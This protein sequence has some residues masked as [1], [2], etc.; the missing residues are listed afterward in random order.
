MAWVQSGASPSRASRLHGSRWRQGQ[1]AF[2]DAFRR[3][4]GRFRRWSG[5]LARLSTSPVDKLVEKRTGIAGKGRSAC[6]GSPLHKKQADL[7]N[8]LNKMF[9]VLSTGNMTV[10]ICHG[11][12]AETGNGILVRLCTT[13][14]QKSRKRAVSVVPGAFAALHARHAL[15]LEMAI[16]TD[17]QSSKTSSFSIRTCATFTRGSFR[18]KA[19]MDSARVSARL[20]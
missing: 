17:W 1:D 8:L 19:A 5:G 10:I 3:M 2:R 9:F 13:W 12:R 11:R 4:P 7:F 6:P 18:A 15:C 20:T 14:R 16:P